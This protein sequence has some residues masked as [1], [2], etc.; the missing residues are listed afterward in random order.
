MEISYCDSLTTVFRGKLPPS[1]KRLKIY[2]CEKL[3]CL[4]DDNEEDTCSSSSMMHK[5]NVNAS[6][7]HLEDLYIEGCPSLRCLPLIHQLS[8]S[9]TSLVIWNCSKLKT[10]SSTGHLPVALKHLTVRECS[11]LTA[12]LPKGQLPEALESLAI[13]FCQK[14]E[15][16]VEKFHNN[17]A[18]CDISIVGCQK[19]KSL[20]EGLETLSSLRNIN[21]ER[22]Q[23]FSSFPKGGFPDS[24][25]RVH[26]EECEKLEALP[27]GI[28]TLSSLIIC[29]CP[30][31]PLSEE[32]L[33]TK[34]AGLSIKGIKQYKALM[35]LRVS[36]NLTSLICL[37][38]S[39]GPDGESFQDEDLR[40]TLP[41][42]LIAFEI[43]NF[44]N[45][46][47]LPFQDLPSLSHLSIKNCPELTSLPILPSSLLQFD[48]YDCP[49]LKEA[50]K[51]DKG[52]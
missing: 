6:T 27:S 25:L 15:S 20:P 21:I 12:I 36:N 10:L 2:G 8:A 47:Y 49:L 24:N 32:G 19:L 41:R 37:V 26:L 45:L 43:Q 13:G 34:L 52:K 33:A 18:L 44:P 46:K 29:D 1:L 42:T 50:C 28:H 17:K 7:C 40:I 31:M 16:I 23:D 51:R 14:L 22:C 39:G 38:I 11:E 30:N 9:L 4:L 3:E 48:I 5:E 35:E